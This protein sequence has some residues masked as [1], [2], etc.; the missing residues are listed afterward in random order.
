MEEFENRSKLINDILEEADEFFSREAMF[1]H[2][3][4]LKGIQEEI[5]SRTGEKL[6]EIALQAHLDKLWADREIVKLVLPSGIIY[7]SRHGEILRY[8]YKLKLWTKHG[9][10]EHVYE[11]VSQVKY[12][13][14]PKLVPE[15][16]RP[17]ASLSEAFRD[18]RFAS[19]LE[20]EYDI[21]PVE[22]VRDALL[23]AGFVSLSNF[24][25]RSCKAVAWSWLAERH[26]PVIM[27]APTGGGKTLAFLITPLIF[28]LAERLKHPNET[29]TR[30]MLVYPRNAL[31]QNQSQIISKII[32]SINRVLKRNIER[33][34]LTISPPLL[35]EPLTDYSGLI[36]MKGRPALEQAYASPRDIVITNTETLKRRLMDPLFQGVFKTLRCCVFDE[37]HI[38]EEIHG[39]NVIYLTR[40]LK[41]LAQR[42]QTRDIL[43]IGASATIAEPTQ[44]AKTL[45]SSFGEPKILMPNEN[46]LSGSGMEYHYFIRPYQSRAPLSVAIDATSCI[47][48]NHRKGGLAKNK[49][50]SNVSLVEKAIGFVDSLDGVNRW[51]KMLQSNEKSKKIYRKA[52]PKSG[53]NFSRF[54]RPKVWHDEKVGECCQSPSKGIDATCPYYS[55]GLCWVLMTDDPSLHFLPTEDRGLVKLDS[56]WVRPY[57]A[58]T[59]RSWKNLDIQQ[60]IFGWKWPPPEFVDLVVATTALEVGVDFNNVK[61]IFMYKGLRSPTSYRQRAGRAGREEHSN[62][63]IASI[64]SSI[65]NEM[66]YFR[67]FMSLVSPSFQPVPLKAVNLD[68]IRNHLFCALFDLAASERV[69]IWDVSNAN[70]KPNVE[71]AKSIAKTKGPQFLSTINEDSSLIEQAIANFENA[72]DLLSSSEFS[73]IVGLTGPFVDVIIQLTKNSAARN[74]LQASIAHRKMAAKDATKKYDQIKEKRQDCYDLLPRLE[75]YPEIGKLFLDALAE[76][77]KVLE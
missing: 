45:F 63:L 62:S 73:D 18:S 61:E 37:I 13:R 9:E 3:T 29:G 14:T 75:K 2:G 48:H 58:K 46:E 60:E 1:D 12:V 64:V 57:T 4:T 7:R 42:A 41:A 49:K 5:V 32:E 27:T 24:Q 20:N 16:V 76:V 74:K 71:A 10:E 39:T 28:C 44:Y 21:D 52:G 56:V 47:L 34:G 65:P 51:A 70:F 38:Y 59:E 17:I 11:D 53:L 19:Y 68:I 31:A 50:C 40:R 30:L 22:V 8:L 67:H 35:A 54:F 43:L 66:Y 26:D 36:S 23:E 25:L 77:G 33:R 55:Q 69:D 72:L 6:S 15:R